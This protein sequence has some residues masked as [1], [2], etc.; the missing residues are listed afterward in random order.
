MLINFSLEIS[1]F[2]SCKVLNGK[3]PRRAVS[4]LPNEHKST[5]AW[6]ICVCEKPFLLRFGNCFRTFHLH[7]AFPHHV[8]STIAWKAGNVK[9]HEFHSNRTPHDAAATPHPTYIAK[10]RKSA[11]MRVESEEIAYH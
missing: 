10:Y 8:R 6:I 11:P 7:L 9:A 3:L 1:I 4:Q 2:F 5:S